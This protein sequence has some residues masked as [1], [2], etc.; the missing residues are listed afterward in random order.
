MRLSPTEIIHIKQC[1]A[2]FDP[3]AR[4]FLFGSRVDNSKKGGDIDLLILSQIMDFHS[5]IELKMRL[6]DYM[7][8]QKMD[9]VIEPDVSKPFI[10]VIYQ[11]AIE[12]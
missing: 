3:E 4:V 11:K 10:R 8:E 9:I 2:G 7:E 1:V 5:K 12:L 6:L